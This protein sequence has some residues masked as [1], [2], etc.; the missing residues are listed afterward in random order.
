[1]FGRYN[2]KKNI[3]DINKISWAGETRE[4]QKRQIGTLKTYKNA[5]KLKSLT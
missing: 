5:A 3:S 1:V 2:K 4:P